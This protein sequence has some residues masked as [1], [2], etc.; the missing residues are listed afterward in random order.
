MHK[1]HKVLRTVNRHRALVVGLLLLGLVTAS[2]L[3]APLLTEHNP[4]M[5]AP[6]QRLLPI[7]HDVHRLG[8]DSLGRDQVSRLLYG[9]RTSLGVGAAVVVIS[10]A[11]GVLIG[12]AGAVSRRLDAVIMRLMD[13]MMAFPSVI[14]AIALV[15][16]LGPRISNIVIALSIVYTPRMARVVRS[17]VLTVKE[18]D[19]V[20]AA[21][22]LGA[23]SARIVF[24]H[25]LLNSWG[26]IIVQATMVFAGTILAEASLNFLGVGGEPDLP[27]WGGML[28]EARNYMRQMPALV[29]APGIWLMTTVLALNL[30]GDG[31]RDVA[32]PH[33]RRT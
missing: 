13:G 1:L 10:L 22:A 23:G 29:A 26:P 24:R 15:A 9:G 7:G 31:L 17:A 19:Y 8:T 16:A 30:L 11:S 2:S 6:A 18:N 20:V 5:V 32:D 25:I 3:A 33:I 27:S 4:R 21:Q 14:L 28:S 12:T